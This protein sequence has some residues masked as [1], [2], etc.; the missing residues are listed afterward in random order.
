MVPGCRVFSEGKAPPDGCDA[1]PMDLPPA[2]QLSPSTAS[3]VVLG[4]SSVPFAGVCEAFFTAAGHTFDIYTGWMQRARDCARLKDAARQQRILG[5]CRAHPST[6]A[7]RF[8]LH[9]F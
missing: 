6:E 1:G 7:A 8:N 4:M 3:H 9:G 2:C 5:E